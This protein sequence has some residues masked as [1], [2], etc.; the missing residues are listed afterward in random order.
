M[1]DIDHWLT[2]EVVCPYCGYEHG[3]SHEYFIDGNDSARIDCNECG[4]EFTAV[5]DYD[6]RY[7]TH[8]ER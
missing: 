7:T 4:K 6:A 8:K 1:T 5:A 3:E 2:R